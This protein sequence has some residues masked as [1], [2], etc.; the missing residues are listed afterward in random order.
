MTTPKVDKTDSC[1]LHTT[2]TGPRVRLRPLQMR[3]CDALVAA[4]CDGELWN[5][6]YTVVPSADTVQAYVRSVL[7]SREAGTALPFATELAATGQV[8]GCTRFWKI[9]RADRKLEI[10][11]TWLA[12]S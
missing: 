7:G 12:A 11:G 6:P 9:A 5:S 3:D 2:L 4:A 1:D 10:G 8:I